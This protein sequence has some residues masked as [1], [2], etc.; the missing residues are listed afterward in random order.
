MN[1][2]DREMALQ[3]KIEET[4]L[5][6]KKRMMGL[7]SEKEFKIA[8]MKNL[9]DAQ[10][11]ESYNDFR[12]ESIAR[13]LITEQADIAQT[14][15]STVDYVSIFK[16]MNY[17]ELKSTVKAGLNEVW[18]RADT[19][20]TIKD[21]PTKST[22]IEHMEVPDG[23]A[24]P[25]AWREKELAKLADILEANQKKF[26]ENQ[27]EE[28]KQELV[29]GLMK[30]LKENNVL[31]LLSLVKFTNKGKERYYVATKPI[32]EDRII[33][34]IVLEENNYNLFSI[35]IQDSVEQ[36]YD[37]FETGSNIKFKLDGVCCDFC[38]DIAGEKTPL[39]RVSIIRKKDSVK[40]TVTLGSDW[41][42]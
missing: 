24:D 33:D 42:E 37:A 38:F 10:V 32:V 25:W 15:D 4:E 19:V 40:V 34:N 17:E 11:T 18:H 13:G 22:A 26:S 14:V 20:D 39:M 1:F 16:K 31:D 27:I 30:S 7:I 23:V 29:S 2:A 6:M 28:E 5:L 12:D 41:S 35:A 9:K 8:M 36:C 21:I 3:L